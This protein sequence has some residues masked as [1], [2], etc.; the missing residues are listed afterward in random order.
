[1]TIT[2][3]AL[4]LIDMAGLD[5]FA[6]VRSKEYYRWSN[7]KRGKARLGAEEIERISAEFP[8]YRWW[9]MTGD[10]L[11][12]AGQTSPEYDEA[13]SKLPSHNAG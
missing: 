10:V 7:I 4:L 13:N 3:R 6:E 5:A 1:M 8:Q 2:D 9:L 12:E 11:P